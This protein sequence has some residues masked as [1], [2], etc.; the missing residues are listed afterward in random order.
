MILV[1]ITKTT[2]MNPKIIEFTL[3]FKAKYAMAG[4]QLFDV[5]IR[6]SEK[7]LGIQKIYEFQ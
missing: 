7:N 6:L 1:K 5:K 4:N 2:K 3:S